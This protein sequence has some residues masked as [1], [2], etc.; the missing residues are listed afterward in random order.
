MDNNIYNLPNAL[1]VF[2]FPAG[3][4]LLWLLMQYGSADT[5]DPGRIWVSVLIAIFAV[6][7]FLSDLYDGKLAR[8]RGIVTNFGK[9]LDPVADSMLFTLLMLGLAM[10]PRFNITIW[11]TV[12]MLYR[13]AGVQILRRY[14]AVGGVVL[15]AGWAGKAKMFVQ[16]IGMGVLAF[17]LLV[18]DLSIIKIPEVI[19]VEFAWWAS[20]L[21]AVVGLISLFLYIKQLPEMM[22]EQAGK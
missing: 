16:C 2:R 19:I 3:V 5:A 10:S 9:M 14:A 20:A 13:E 7:A 8:S 15:M 21:S 4:V 17:M 1:T 22:K 6:L 12:I 18:S 11:F